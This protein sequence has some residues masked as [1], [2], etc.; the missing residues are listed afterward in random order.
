MAEQCYERE[1]Q[2]MNTQRSNR[3]ALCGLLAAAL[4]LL[5]ACQ[6]P[7]LAAHSQPTQPA[8]PP[9]PPASQTPADITL[10]YTAAAQNVTI[11][12]VPAQ[13]AS[14]DGP[15]WEAAPQYRLVTLQ[16]YPVA[17][18]ALKPQI[19]IYPVSE[20]AAANE[21][22]GKVTA[23]LQTLLQSRQAGD[24]L[25]FL[26]L[27]NAAQMMHVQMQY[28]DSENGQGVRYLTQFSQGLN[29]INNSELIYTFQGLTSDGKYYIAAVLPV[30]YPELPASNAPDDQPA[31]MLDDYPAY[32]AN[33]V[34]LLDQQTANS[35]TPDLDQLDALIRSLEIQ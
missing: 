21:N 31:G 24:R 9:A 12:T 19:F 2:T 10:D 4:L 28:L 22:A 8:E 3:T 17:S 23:E 30:T 6:F 27:V 29:P 16:G 32:I 18:H 20:L 13:P 5:T 26:P 35:F 11:E 25:P 14:A 33:T 34:S 7:T 15:Y 1:N